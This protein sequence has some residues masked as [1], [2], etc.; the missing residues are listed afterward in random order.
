MKRSAEGFVLAFPPLEG[1]PPFEPDPVIEAY[2]EDVD[3]HAERRY[4]PGE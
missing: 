1:A 2:K 4:H 3:R